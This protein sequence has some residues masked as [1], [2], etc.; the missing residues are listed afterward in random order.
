MFNEAN[1]EAVLV[2][3]FDHMRE[4][5]PS[6]YVTYNGDWFDWPFIET[7]ALKHGLDMYEQIGFYCNR[8]TN[9][10]LSR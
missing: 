2:R 1:E 5:K 9:E 7:R 10:T 8:K 4:V 6:I 3:F